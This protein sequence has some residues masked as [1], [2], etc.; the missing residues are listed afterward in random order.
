MTPWTLI[1]DKHKKNKKQTRASSQS[2]I[3]HRA[4][5]AL[6]RLTERVKMR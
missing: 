4:K 6:V 5:E 1:V 3:L 2:F